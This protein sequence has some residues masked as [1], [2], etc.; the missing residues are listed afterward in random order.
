M[1]GTNSPSCCVYEQPA[2]R[3]VTGDTIRPGGLALTERALAHCALPPGARVLDVGCG[4]GATVEHLRRTHGLR[5]VG[6]DPS[7]VLLQAGMERTS[8]LPL[9][10]AA[11]ER[12]PFANGVFDA[13]F[14]EC[15]LSLMDA[16]AA[17]S[18]FG[19]VLRPGGWLIVSDMGAGNP[20]ALA[21]ARALP[22]SCCASGAM[23]RSEVTAL[24]EHAGFT[25][26]RWE[27][28]SEELRQLTVQI[29]F[30]HGS[31]ENFW[32]ALA[33]EAACACNIQPVLARLKPGYFLL[34]A[35]KHAA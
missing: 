19:R 25:V 32:R 5:A 7:R 8:D 4:T 9:G 30:E 11:G 1:K 22:L 29:I 16:P 31:M 24:V 20:A 18:E 26:E 6:I 33:G 34:I 12:L 23:P 10:A 28:H 3:D 35:R 17:L 21:A 27:D 14:A 13:L 2:I 15:C